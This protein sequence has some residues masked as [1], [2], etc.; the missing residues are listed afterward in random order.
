MINYKTI[1]VFL[2]ILMETIGIA[3]AQR[4]HETQIIGSHNSY[5]KG[6]SP[7]ILEY[8]KN[9]NPKAAISLQYGHIPLIEQLDLGLRSLELDVF[10]DPAGG[11]YSD[12]KGLQ[13]IRQDNPEFEF[14]K[15]G[16][17]LKPGLKLFHVQDIDIESYHYLFTGALLEIKD[18][19]NSNPNHHPIIILIN[20]KDSEVSDTVSPLKFTAAA[21]DSIDLEI[22]NALGKD[23]LIT[24][25][26]VKG[27][28]RTLEDAILAEGWPEMSQL[29]GKFLFVLDEKEEKTDQYLSRHPELKEAVMFVNVK[30]D[31]PNAA[32]RIINNPIE[33]HSYIQ[34]LVRKGY[35]VRTRAD[36][37]TMEAR[38]NDYSRFEK[39]KSS[40]AQVIS[41]DYYIPSQII[42][43][44]FQ[45]V[46]EAGKYEREN[47]VK[48]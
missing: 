25:A 30:E 48:N 47:P 13:I 36:S 31:N 44:P 42:D 12:P 18:W 15:S 11:R 41:T 34:E 6:I 38:E 46:F 1:F 4:L 22:K 9:V 2:F 14:D 29:K 3:Q 20:A 26:L 28:Y 27:K 7:L 16:D 39:A 17:L 43:S 23:K 45:I 33:N 32:F 21:L 19:S 35:L 8:L 24:P 40:G 5:K 10:H 37:D